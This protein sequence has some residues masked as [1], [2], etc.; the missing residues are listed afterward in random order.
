MGAG[1]PVGVVFLDNVMEEIVGDIHDEFDSEPSPFTRI[2]DDEFIVEGTLP[3][4]ELSDHVPGLFL[5]SEEV[6]TIGGHITKQLGRF[7]EV[8]ETLEVLGYEARVT[9]ADG[10]RV[11]QIHFRK[12]PEPGDA[13]ENAA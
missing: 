10:R 12:L 2:N 3:L 5:D 4:I 9:S 11:G 1:T 6:S 13:D 8:G 7:P